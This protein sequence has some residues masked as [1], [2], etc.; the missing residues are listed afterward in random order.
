M[1]DRSRVM[2]LVTAGCSLAKRVTVIDGI[3][4]R[5]DE[6]PW[7]RIH[8]FTPVEVDSPESLYEVLTTAA[9]MDPA[10]CVVRAEPKAETGRRAIHDDPEKGPAGMFP[11]PRAWVGFDIENVP[12][13]Y[14]HMT[15][16]GEQ[17]TLRFEPAFDGG[18]I[19][20]YVRDCL[21]PEFH[22]ATGVWQMTASAGKRLDELRCRLWYLLDKPL[23]GRQLEAWCKP[24]IDRKWLDPSTLRDVTP[25]FVG[26]KIL[27]DQQD[28]IVERWGILHE[29]HAFV[30]VPA[31]VAAA[32]RREH[33]S[34][35][36][37]DIPAGDPE[38]LR[39]RYGPRLEQRL[40]EVV[41]QIDEAI[42]ATAAATRGQRHPTYLRA[43]ATITGLCRYWCIDIDR[44]R[45][46]LIEAY[47]STLSPEEAL[48]RERGSIEG[49]WNWL[50]KGGRSN[51]TEPQS[52]D[53][54]AAKLA[55]IA[56]D[57][58]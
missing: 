4:C 8:A 56:G 52:T 9:A 19:A 55:E 36:G 16:N 49:V 15:M 51:A 41:A 5:T 6:P 23:D 24:A 38:T 7:P 46:L 17:V 57:V 34:Y 40:Q 50:E 22:T 1:T 48:K 12:N 21:P 45:E 33:R 43:A 32:P 54:L 29:E 13:A 58:R 53:E 3:V 20:E 25:H 31:Y 27:G 11:I 44:P 37:S 35:R 10:P 26:V 28:P 14:G 42:A 18:C 39:C 30:Q 2:T 47:L